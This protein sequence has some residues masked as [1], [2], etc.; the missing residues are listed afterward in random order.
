MAPGSR[1][2]PGMVD[3]HMH[4]LSRDSGATGIL[5][6][7][8]QRHRAGLS[9]TVRRQVAGRPEPRPVSQR[10]GGAES[11]AAARSGSRYRALPGDVRS[12]A[13]DEVRGCGDSGRDRRPQPGTGA[14][15]GAGRRHICSQLPALRL[16]GFDEHETAGGAPSR[17]R[18]FLTQVVHQSIV[19]KP[20][21]RAAFHFVWQTVTR[22]RAHRTLVAA[23]AGAGLALVLQG[24]TAALAAGDHRWWANPAGPLL[25]AFIVLPVFLATGQRYSFTVPSDLRANWL[26]RVCAVGDP[27]EYLAGVR[28]VAVLLVVAPL[29]AVLGPV[30]L[31]LWGWKTGGLHVL[32]G[33]VSA[34]LL[35]EAQLVGL[36]KVPFT[37]SYVPGK[38]NL[39][40][41][42]TM[43]VLGYLAYVTVWSWL[44][45]RILER[46]G[47]MVWFLFLA[48]IAQD[49]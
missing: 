8:P 25:P 36:G 22:N 34:W 35:L 16:A 30:Y 37:C 43:Y 42:W 19:R 32:F 4:A 11:A 13:P 40:I 46:P 7:D 10:S 21:E 41:W 12:G 2:S 23:W 29:C 26:F 44:D 28:K 31:V 5:D 24:V 39:K 1:F 20:A 48:A 49:R 3:A 6:A 17:L 15:C 47:L 33:T 9:P 27:A 14:G 18:A 45:L 38:A